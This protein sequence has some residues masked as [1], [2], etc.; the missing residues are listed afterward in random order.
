MRKD[1][2]TKAMSRAWSVDAPELTVSTR[3]PHNVAER[4]ARKPEPL[5]MPALAVKTRRAER[6]RQHRLRDRQQRAKRTDTKGRVESHKRLLKQEQAQRAS[7]LAMLLDSAAQRRQQLLDQKRA[8]CAMHL[9][10]AQ[11]VRKQQETAQEQWRAHCAHRLL[12]KAKTARR[13]TTSKDLAAT[14]IQQWF[15]VQT[16]VQA[17]KRLQTQA[18]LQEEQGSEAPSFETVTRE[19]QDEQVLSDVEHIL[20]VLALPKAKKAAAAAAAAAAATASKTTTTTTVS[21]TPTET[22][23][24]Q[25]K[26]ASSKKPTVAETTSTPPQ[27]RKRSASKAGRGADTDADSAATRQKKALRWR[28]RI[29]LSAFL[30]THH[31][32]AVLMTRDDAMERHLFDCASTLVATFRRWLQHVVDAGHRARKYAH[33]A[34]SELT[35]AIRHHVR[36]FQAWQ[37][38]DLDSLAQSLVDHYKELL[39]LKSAV[40]R[41]KRSRSEWHP[42]I[43]DQLTMIETRMESLGAQEK[44]HECLAAKETHIQR[45]EERRRAAARAKATVIGTRDSADTTPKPTSPEHAAHR[46]RIEQTTTASSAAASMATSGAGSSAGSRSTSTSS[47]EHDGNGDGRSSDQDSSTGAMKQDSE[48]EDKHHE[49]PSTPPSPSTTRKPAAPASES[50][51]EGSDAE[52]ADAAMAK[53]LAASWDLDFLHN[54]CVDPTF[55]LTSDRELRFYHEEYPAHPPA[56]VTIPSAAATTTAATTTTGAHANGP[57]GDM[58]YL[59]RRIDFIS[60][61]AL[62]DQLQQELEADG[63]PDVTRWV[64]ILRDLVDRLCAATLPRQQRLRDT[65]R[66]QMDAENTAAAL[67]DRFMTADDVKAFVLKYI[68]MLAAP[69]RDE[70]VAQLEAS[71]STAEFLFNAFALLEAMQLDLANYILETYRPLILKYGAQL[72]RDRIQSLVFSGALTFDNT[73]KWLAAAVSEAGVC[74]S[75]PY[76]AATTNTLESTA[77][78]AQKMTFSEHFFVATERLLFSK[79]CDDAFPET[80]VADQPLITT[81]RQELSAIAHTCALYTLISHKVHRIKHNQ[82]IA[83]E[84]RE[85]ML[86]AFMTEGWTNGLDDSSHRRMCTFAISAINKH[87]QPKLTQEEE[88][89]IRDEPFGA[90]APVR[91]PHQARAR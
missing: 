30:I 36:A 39:S 84:F 34:D 85:L 65:I 48:D 25:A 61:K 2:K 72:E 57:Q 81:A 26:E 16:L 19:I 45:Q 4:F 14:R 56:H 67:R 1:E 60:R 46:E 31:R 91:P 52:D 29:V 32:E 3:K 54:V 18:I 77:E 35:R 59:R 33:I 90:G 49:R 40:G 88:A 74:A 8:K 76:V 43:D 69:S 21:A 75:E 44:L 11:A 64:P 78:A 89:R 20:H 13:L 86:G 10:K 87:L 82:D 23:A 28:V 53:Q 47:S 38:K 42:H 63:S 17:C 15:R 73:E 55:R 7:A 79:E 27:S 51:S 68:K 5:T 58:A 50:G 83:K 22:A 24:D 62:M 66:E 80:L 9:D 70:R 71:G 41:H 12:Q 6:R 37:S